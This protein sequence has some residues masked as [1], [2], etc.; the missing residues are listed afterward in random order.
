MRRKGNTSRAQKLSQG[1]IWESWIE[2]SPQERNG[3]LTGGLRPGRKRLEDGTLV[4]GVCEGVERRTIVAIIEIPGYHRRVAY[5]KT[6]APNG[7]PE[8]GKPKL[9]FTAVGPFLKWI[10]GTS[11]AHMKPA[12][13][14]EAGTVE[15]A[16]AILQGQRES[17]QAAVAA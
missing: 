13:R 6:F 17:Q 8:F 9:H 3:Q 16:L 15:R 11:R 4:P 7:H 1:E 10:N 14:I 12:V 2:F 5:T